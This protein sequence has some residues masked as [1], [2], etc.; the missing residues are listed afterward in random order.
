MTVNELISILQT[1]KNGKLIEPEILV[2]G[3]TVGGV[4]L[5]YSYDGTFTIDLL[6]EKQEGK[7]EV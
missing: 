3:R 5:S 4:H 1:A 7:V 6:A 2:G